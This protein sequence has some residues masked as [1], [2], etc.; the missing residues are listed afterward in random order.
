MAA[1]PAFEDV[2]VDRIALVAHPIP[3]GRAVFNYIC[4]LHHTPNHR[5][6][7]QIAP[8][9]TSPEGEARIR[10]AYNEVVQAYRTLRNL[11][12][13]NGELDAAARLQGRAATQLLNAA[14]A[15]E[16]MINHQGALDIFTWTVHSFEDN[17]QDRTAALTLIRQNFMNLV[18][19]LTTRR[20]I[21][22]RVQQIDTAIEQ[23]RAPPRTLPVF[24]DDDVDV[25]WQGPIHVK[26][27]F[28]TVGDH[29][30]PFPLPSEAFWRGGHQDGQDADQRLQD[31]GGE[32]STRAQPHQRGHHHQDCWPRR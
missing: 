14:C 25:D 23:R 30:I 8:N 7:G 10:Q 24:R 3:T 32:G 20:E 27:A 11:A 21:R 2:T 4:K 9:C 19:G 17:G 1:A 28:H 6:P 29:N 22:D 26:P 18:V 12:A 16:P 31:A 15:C 5:R 13:I